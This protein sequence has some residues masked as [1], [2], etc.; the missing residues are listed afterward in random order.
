MQGAGALEAER[1]PCMTSLEAE[2][3]LPRAVLGPGAAKHVGAIGADLCF[4][5]HVVRAHE[6]QFEAEQGAWSL[7]R[8][9]TPRWD[10]TASSGDPRSVE[11]GECSRLPKS[12]RSREP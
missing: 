12:P 7:G 2:P 4:G 9:L 11:N 10:E 5:C 8:V 3:V 1:S 6:A